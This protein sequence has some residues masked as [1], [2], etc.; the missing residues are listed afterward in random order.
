MTAIPSPRNHFIS[1]SK[2]GRKKLLRNNLILFSALMILIFVA[3]LMDDFGRFIT[4]IALL[5]V[6]ISGVFAAEYGKRIFNI[7]ISLGLLVVLNMI[8]SI[9]FP[10][11]TILSITSFILVTLSLI[12]STIAL[13]FHMSMAE[14]V[15]KST[16]L[17][18][19][20]SYLLL[21]L[22]A[23]TLFIT[24]DLFIPNSFMSL[25][26]GEGNVSSFIYFGFVTLTTLGYGDITPSAPLAKSLS[27]FVAVAGQ[28][29]LVIV[30]ALI[31]GKFLSTRNRDNIVS[32]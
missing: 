19:I 9:L 25:E 4:R 6:V 14:T 12:L 5:I 27:I 23:S 3:P 30:M 20:N 32:D 17:C 29:Y 13:I 8:L 1:Q 10:E 22:V 11:I 16:I 31:I 7:L 21:G 26:R 28:L 15:E 2:E 18:A 24:L